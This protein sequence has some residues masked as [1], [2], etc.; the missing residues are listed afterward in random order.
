MQSRVTIQDVANMAKVSKVTV[1]YVLNGRDASVRISPGT[2]QRVLDAAKELGYAPNAVARML[3]TRRSSTI[4]VV[5]QYATFF[6]TWSSFTSDLMHGVCESCVQSDYDLMLHTKVSDNADSEADSLTDGRVD[7]VLLLRDE[8]DPLVTALIERNFPSVLFFSRSSHP[9]AAFVD[10]DNYTGGKIAVQHL[11]DLGHKNIGMI[12]GSQQSVSSNDRFSGY[13]DALES[14]G[15]PVET[16]KILT[17]CTPDADRN[18]LYELLNSPERP[19][20]LFVWSD[21]VAYQIMRACRECNLSIPDDISI[22]GFDSLE[23]SKLSSPPLT[24]VRQPVLDMAR[25]ATK[26][27]LDL[28]NRKESPRTQIIYPLT[29]DI[30]GSTKTFSH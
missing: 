3:V 4:A 20:A 19:S 26:L 5:F 25:E 6:S 13:R 27:L 1:S 15:I 16:S 29:L 28:I 18:A 7:G 30:R 24:S 11:I 21:D 14:A 10:S 2:K 9:R 17:M 12:R 22:V 23:S 8:N